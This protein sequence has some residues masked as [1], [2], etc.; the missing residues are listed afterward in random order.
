MSPA[1]KCEMFVC[2]YVSNRNFDDRETPLTGDT[3]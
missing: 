1:T 2:V 3:P